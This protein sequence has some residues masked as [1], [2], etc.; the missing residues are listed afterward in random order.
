M[1]T[2]KKMWSSSEAGTVSTESEGF[3]KWPQEITGVEEV[4]VQPLMAL[5]SAAVQGT[6]PA[7]QFL[8][9]AAQRTKQGKELSPQCDG[10][11]FLLN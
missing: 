2:E 11:H 4:S 7:S 8:L 10:F 9:K 5:P 1:K 6:A 3:N